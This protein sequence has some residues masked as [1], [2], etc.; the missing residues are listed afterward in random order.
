MKVHVTRE[1]LQ[2]LADGQ[3][4][5]DDAQSVKRHLAECTACAS[6]FG[7][8]TRFDRFMRAIPVPAVRNDFT[9]DLLSRL[10]IPRR[11]SLM[12]RLLGHA[13]SLVAILLVVLMGGSI[14]ALLTF[15]NGGE[16]V[17]QEIPGQRLVDDG[18]KWLTGVYVEFGNWLSRVTGTLPWGQGAKI[19]VILL[20]MVT[21][22]SVGERRADRKRSA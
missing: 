11:S 16:G 14:W 6:A 18:G 8:M 13:A 12:F 15:A 19:V 1:M 10:G 17:T 9:E 22:I 7:A 5:G 4:Q 2:L 3:L 21:L 20:F